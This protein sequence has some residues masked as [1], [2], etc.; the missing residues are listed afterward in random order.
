MAVSDIALKQALLKIKQSLEAYVGCISGAIL[1][2]EIANR[3]LDAGLESVVDNRH[4][5][6]FE[7]LCDGQH[8]Q[9][10]RN[11]QF[12]ML[13]CNTSRYNT[14]QRI[15]RKGDA[16]VR[17]QRVCRQRARGTSLKPSKALNACCGGNSRC[18]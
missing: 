13:R 12:I 18:C 8:E 6:R 5:C 1:I 16:N 2:E 7:R 15:G 3:M 4:R 10:L 11:I 9:L 14:S 17:C